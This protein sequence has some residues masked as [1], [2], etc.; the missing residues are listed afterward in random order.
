V[1]ASVPFVRPLV[2][3]GRIA[4]RQALASRTEVLGRVAFYGVLLL[5]FSQLWRV[6]PL[7]GADPR[8]RVW[9]IA[10]TEWVLLSI[11]YVHL[12]LERD[13]SSGDVAY[14]LPQPVSYVALKVAEGMG[15]FLARLAVIGA[16]GV[17]ATWLFAGGFPAD[18]RG[19]PFAIPLALL[20][21]AL[22]IV[23]QTTI[24]VTSIWLADVS[25]V[26]WIWQKCCFVLG[27]LILPLEV[28][29]AWLAAAA[30]WTP[31]SALLYGPGRTALGYAPEAFA[32]SAASLV[33][34]TLIALAV[35]K[36]VVA[37]GLRVLDVNGG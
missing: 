5:V 25:P 4:A 2:A 30:R 34:W 23:V 28:Y 27:G 11:P 19:L 29:P 21:G 24:G 8:A 37:R 1:S 10:V 22:G 3:V 12:E 32:G 13:F 20:A 31:F 35:L 26:Y 36:V 18:A 33:V 17:P 15:Q 16:F 9:Y 7:G 6:V 14:F